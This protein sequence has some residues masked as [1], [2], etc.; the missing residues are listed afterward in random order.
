MKIEIDKPKNF[1]LVLYEIG[2]RHKKRID[3]CETK[4]IRRF[5]TKLKLLNS[6]IESHLRVFYAHGGHN[7]GF[8]SSKEDLLFAFDAFVE[9]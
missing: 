5:M 9:N 4:S 8:Y 7:E 2:S 1:T 3:R 6:Q